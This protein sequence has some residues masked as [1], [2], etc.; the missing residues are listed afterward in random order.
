MNRKA[1]F[2]VP[3][4]LGFGWISH[5]FEASK[6]NLGQEAYWQGKMSRLAVG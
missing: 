1:I 3:V 2:P 5:F 4:R 6:I